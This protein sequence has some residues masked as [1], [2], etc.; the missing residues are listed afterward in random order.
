[1][2]V[3]FGYGDNSGRGY[4]E[5]INLCEGGL[6]G[7]DM[8]GIESE[9]GDVREGSRILGVPCIDHDGGF[10]ISE[11]EVCFYGDSGGFE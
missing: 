11:D 7:V 2:G 8:G 10:F 9:P 3:I 4:E 1:M 5:V 6:I